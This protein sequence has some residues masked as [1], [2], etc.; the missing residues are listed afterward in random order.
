MPTRV[1]PSR[2]VRD[3]GPQAGMGP[4]AIVV[5]DSLPEERDQMSFME[6]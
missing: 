5:T 3:A 2:R 6:R 1:R 4:A